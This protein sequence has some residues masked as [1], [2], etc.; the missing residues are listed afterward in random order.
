MQTESN[1]LLFAATDLT[2][3]QLLIMCMVCGLLTITHVASYQ[4]VAVVTRTAVTAHSVV[5]L[6]VTPSVSG[7]ALVNIC[8]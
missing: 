8:K 3:F 4:R 1:K 2:Q 7:A 6:M 5:A